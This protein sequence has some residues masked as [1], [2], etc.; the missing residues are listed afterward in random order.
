MLQTVTVENVQFT[1]EEKTGSGYVKGQCVQAWPTCG[2]YPTDGMSG[3]V[4][5]NAIKPGC[6]W[7]YSG[8]DLSGDERITTVLIWN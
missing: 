1:I 7:S 6:S 8:K 4:I 5:A 3:D 2:E